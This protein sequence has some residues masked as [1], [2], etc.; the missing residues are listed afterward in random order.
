VFTFWWSAMTPAGHCATHTPHPLHR[1][2]L[3]TIA[4]L[5]AIIEDLITI[6]TKIPFSF[7]KS[8]LKGMFLLFFYL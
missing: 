3:T 7:D 4:P 6:F 8:K 5:N 1:S 2:V